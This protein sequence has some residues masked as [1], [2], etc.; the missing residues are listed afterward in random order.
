MLKL[1]VVGTILQS[2][3][4]KYTLHN[5]QSHAANEGKF[6]TAFTR[7]P[8]H[9]GKIHSAFTILYYLLLLAQ[10]LMC[11][12]EIVRLSLAHLGTGLLGFTFA[13]LITAGTLRYTQGI[14]GIV[15][16][17]R[18]VNLALWISLAIT[19]GL[20]ISEEVKE[21]IHGRKG[22]KYPVV[23]QFTDVLVMI[24]VYAILGTLETCLKP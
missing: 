14:K 2:T 16:E 12:L 9:H 23:D 4:G 5:G 8:R 22:T 24:G 13:A 19:N 20:K 21:G 15:P 10:G 6:Q 11:I 1:C 17:W 7:D 3:R 18:W